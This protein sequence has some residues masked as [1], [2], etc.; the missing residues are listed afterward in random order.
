MTTPNK[1]N[2]VLLIIWAVL[3]MSACSQNKKEDQTANTSK[4]VGKSA[5][6]SKDDVASPNPIVETTTDESGLS[7][8]DSGKSETDNGPTTV[9]FAQ[10]KTSKTYNNNITGGGSHTY[11]LTASAGQTISIQINSSREDAGFTVYNPAGNEISA[12]EETTEVREFTEELSDSGRYKIIV[13]SPRNISYDITF[14]VSANSRDLTPKEAG[15][16]DNKTVKFGSGNSTASY[17]NSVIRGE[18]DTYN[19]G[20]RAGQFMTV[21][22]TSVENNASFQV[23]GLNGEDLVED[24]TNWTGEL[25]ANGNY[26]IIVG[27]TR[28]N[29]TYTIKFSVVQSPI[30]H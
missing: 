24:G 6:T 19:L 12:A 15:G 8:E 27:P 3:V 5:N 18:Q 28:G 20:A 1:T 17:S 7:E 9:K 26:K 16:G 21:S 10:G 30:D 4:E 29:A 22:I 14:E 11:F 13:S 25:P 2:L 23:V